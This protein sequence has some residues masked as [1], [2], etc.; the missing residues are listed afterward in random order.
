MTDSSSKLHATKVEILEHILEV[1]G[2]IN[3][4]VNRL[5]ER[6]LR[7]D[8]SKL[9]DL[10]LPYFAE[11][12]SLKTITFGSTEYEEAL[13][14]LKPALD[15]HYANN[16]HHPQHFENG[17]KG[18]TLIDLVEMY[19]DWKSSV[20]RHTD[21]DLMNSIEINKK[22]FNMSDELTEIFKNTAQVI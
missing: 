1:Q 10:E 7:H 13:A 22:R 4:F 16:S 5:T 18:M 2:E 14:R 17:I 11:A 6:G 20:K 12:S 8:R 15:N 3:M 21:G 19:C 9:T